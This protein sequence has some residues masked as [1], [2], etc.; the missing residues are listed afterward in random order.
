MNELIDN[1]PK[2]ILLLERIEEIFGDMIAHFLTEVKEVEPGKDPTVDIPLPDFG[3]RESEETTLAEAQDEA[4]RLMKERNLKRIAK[5]IEQEELDLMILIRSKIQDIKTL[6]LNY[7]KGSSSSSRIS[8]QIPTFLSNHIQGLE[9]MLRIV[10]VLPGKTSPGRIIYASLVSSKIAISNIRIILDNQLR[11]V[12][13]E[14]GQ[15]KDHMKLVFQQEVDIS[16]MKDFSKAL[17]VWNKHLRAFG[18]L[19]GEHNTEFKIVSVQQGSI[20]VIILSVAAII[21]TLGKTVEKVVDIVKKIYEVKKHIIELKKMKLSGIAKAIDAFEKQSNLSVNQQATE[22]AES[23]IKEYKYTK[24]DANEVKVALIKAI[25]H[26]LHFVKGGGEVNIHLLEPPKENTE[27]EKIISEK[28]L[29]LGQ[30]KSD[31]ILLEETNYT[32]LLEE[33]DKEEVIGWNTV[34]PSL[35]YSFQLLHHKTKVAKA[36][37]TR[38]IKLNMVAVR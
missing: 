25:S 6:I 13:S 18:R 27:I 16:S 29:E 9:N 11:Q 31:M 20:Q 4:K 32:K 19:A 8:N 26:L 36:A 35:D 22:I 30:L 17:G 3:K 15:D 28:F 34:F 10:E 21:F 14:N 37:E 12:L 24:D 7:S 1:L 5:G 23:L 38:P 2:Q 33:M